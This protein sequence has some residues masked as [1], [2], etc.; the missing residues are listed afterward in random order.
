MPFSPHPRPPAGHQDLVTILTGSAGCF[1]RCRSTQRVFT[2]SSPKESE[3]ESNGA[4]RTMREK[5]FGYDTIAL[6]SL[7][8]QIPTQSQRTHTYIIYS[9]NEVQAHGGQ[10]P[11]LMVMASHLSFSLFY[12]AHEPAQLGLH[13]RPHADPQASHDQPPLLFFPAESAIGDRHIRRPQATAPSWDLGSST[14]CPHH[15]P[16]RTTAQREGP[17]GTETETGR[18]DRPNSSRVGG[19]GRQPWGARHEERDTDVVSR[20]EG[21]EADLGS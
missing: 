16:G 5:R 8:Q 3:S 19:A 6:R 11:K 18:P 4:T 1:R 20:W 9:Y 12:H 14:K 15:S 13:T 7:F 2:G 21:A 10:L 17:D